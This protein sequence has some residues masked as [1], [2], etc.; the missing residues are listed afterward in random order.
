M[1]TVTERDLPPVVPAVFQMNPR[2]EMIV[3][4]AIQ[5]TQRLALNG[6]PMFID[7]ILATSWKQNVGQTEV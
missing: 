6:A 3:M 5:A 4:T 7:A 2:T 1:V